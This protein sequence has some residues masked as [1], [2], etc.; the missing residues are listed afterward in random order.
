MKRLCLLIL[1]I[2]CFVTQMMATNDVVITVL[3]KTKGA[4]SLAF[5]RIPEVWI[6]GPKRFDIK[7]IGE[8]RVLN[9]SIYTVTI[10]TTKPI[11]VQCNWLGD[12]GSRM[13]ITPGDRAKAIVEYAENDK[14]KFKVHFSGKM[15]ENYNIY[16]DL[17][18]RF[19]KNSIWNI[20]GTVPLQKSIQIIDSDY[21]SKC[22][23]I[24]TIVKPGLI[25]NLM[26]NEEK[27]FTFYYLE[28][29]DNVSSNKLTWGELIKIKN[30]YFHSSISCENNIYMYDP[31]YSM[32]I[33]SLSDLLCRNIKSKSLLVAQTDTIHKY[34][35]GKL[36]DYLIA[37]CFHS[38]SR[39]S[40]NKIGNISGPDVEKWYS[41]SLVNMQDN[42]SKALMQYSYDLYKKMNNPFP[43][44][45]L[46]EKIIKLS[47]NSVLT[48][49]DLLK[50]NEGSQVI[51]DTWASWCGSCIREIRRGKKNIEELEKRGNH[52]V[53]ISIDKQEDINKAKEKAKALNILD[54]AYVIVGKAYKTY[55]DITY[56]PHY[57]MV[58][59]SSN[60][61]NINL[62]F[63]SSIQNFDKYGE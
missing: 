43:A 36:A 33:G 58:D 44:A 39:K 6:N 19:N 25:Q 46:N 63:L 22:N 14:Q 9:D 3:D 42:E 2:M 30:K 51:I 47:D 16:R 50:E 52:F 15:N 37:S 35:S 8:K 56:I 34:F 40:Y 28:H 5:L 48:F 24:K 26:L 20:I 32:G 38:F 7:S 60:I 13:I 49:R 54:K 31:E 17:N 53:Y 10:Q 57:I 4:S 23:M 27:A 1:S 21:A 62:P 29:A 59:K 18:N 45:I 41:K 55:L 61:K 12:W 11:L